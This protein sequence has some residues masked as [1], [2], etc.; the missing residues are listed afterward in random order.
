MSIANRARVSTPF[1]SFL[2]NE[3][4]ALP[5]EQTSEW[6]ESAERNAIIQFGANRMTT[7]HSSSW[8]PEQRD[9]VSRA[10]ST[11]AMDSGGKLVRRISGAIIG[12]RQL[13]TMWIIAAARAMAK[14]D[15][16]EESLWLS[17]ILEDDFKRTFWYQPTFFDT[18]AS[19][20]KGTSVATLLRKARSH[21]MRLAPAFDLYRLQDHHLHNITCDALGMMKQSQHLKLCSETLGSEVVSGDDIGRLFKRRDAEIHGGVLRR[22]FSYRSTVMFAESF[23]STAQATV[24]GLFSGEI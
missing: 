22:D 8:T 9:A 19:A 21:L 20:T 6:F 15:G 3:I 7:A 5:S 23:A 11:M 17:A 14:S 4:H 13:M 1:E 18:E 2:Y 10:M 12:H 24:D 16:T